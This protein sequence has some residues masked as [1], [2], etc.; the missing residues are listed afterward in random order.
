MKTHRCKKSLENRMSI[1]LIDDIE[2][3]TWTLYNPIIEY[4]YDLEYDYH[5]LNMV[6]PIEYCPFC[7]MKLKEV[8]E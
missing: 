6:C 2:E 1:R 7:G 8:E 3:P 4:D 5:R